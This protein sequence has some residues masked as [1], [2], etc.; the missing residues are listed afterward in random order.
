MS[1]K[2]LVLASVGLA[3][4]A[5]IAFAQ[6]SEFQAKIAAD[7]KA[8]QPR[9]VRNCGASDRLEMRFEGKLDVNPH[10]T[11]PGD[12][13][14]VSTLC[15]AGLAAIEYVCNNNKTVASALSRVTDITCVRGS[16]PLSYKLAGSHLALLFDA[17]YDKTN[18]GGQRDD[19][20]KAFKRDLD[21]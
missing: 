9:I 20:V 13:F 11:A 1:K 10:Q 17:T 12:K 8:Y 7:M 15:T 16:G 5:G 4:I 14:G 19:L 6:Q 18:S 21:R 2:P 3:A